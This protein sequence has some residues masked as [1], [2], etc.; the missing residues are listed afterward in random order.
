LVPPKHGTL[1]LP[2]T[3]RRF[4]AP[5]GDALAGFGVDELAMDAM[6][7]LAVEYVKTM[8]SAVEAAG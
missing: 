7:R 2:F 6:T 1:Q 4:D 5:A 3:R 8:R